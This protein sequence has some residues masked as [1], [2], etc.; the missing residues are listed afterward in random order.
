MLPRGQHLPHPCSNTPTQ[1][2]SCAPAPPPRSAPRIATW[3][4][5]RSRSRPAD[6]SC[7]NLSRNTAPHFPRP[8]ASRR[9]LTRILPRDLERLVPRQAVH[10]ELREQVE[11]DEHALA[12]CADERERVDPKPLHHPVAARD[13]A[14]GHDPAQHVCHLALQLRKVP[15]VVVLQNCQPTSPAC[16]RLTAVC[17]CGTCR[18]QDQRPTHASRG[19]L[20]RC[21]ARASPRAQSR[22]TA[23]RPV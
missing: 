20:P 8:A 19:S 10:A 17:P 23:S 9:P 1:S 21:A 16:P 18:P 11:L 4:T 7:G 6:L 15:K 2:Q 3:E 22:E 12:P 13:P 5:R 14:V